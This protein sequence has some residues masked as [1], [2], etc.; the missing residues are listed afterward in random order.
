M[1]QVAKHY[2]Q[3]KKHIIFKYNQRNWNNSGIINNDSLEVKTNCLRQKSEQL[4][5]AFPIF[6]ISSNETLKKIIKITEIYFY[7]TKKAPS[8]LEIFKFLYYPLFSLS[9]IVE[10][11]EEA[12]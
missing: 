9:A 1:L 2:Q 6:Y 4:K 10:F 8:I 11:V 3:Y 7:C 12:D 5:L